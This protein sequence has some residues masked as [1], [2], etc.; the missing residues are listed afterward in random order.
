MFNLTSGSS[1]DNIFSALVECAYGKD[2]SRFKRLRAV[3]VGR[4]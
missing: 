3:A 1:S 4:T 2:R